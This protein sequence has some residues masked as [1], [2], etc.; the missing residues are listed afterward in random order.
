MKDLWSTIWRVLVTCFVGYTF[1]WIVWKYFESPIEANESYKTQ[2]Y[3]TQ[4][5]NSTDIVIPQKKCLIK[6]NISY[7]TKEKIYHLPWCQNYNDTVIN[8]NYWERW[9]CTE[10]EAIAAGRRKAKNCH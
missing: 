8:T 1:I 6:W 3:K 10:E 7:K 4:S 2:S 5:Y 9:F